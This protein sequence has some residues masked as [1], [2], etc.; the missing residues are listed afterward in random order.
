MEHPHSGTVNPGVLSGLNTQGLP[1]VTAVPIVPIDAAQWALNFPSNNPNLRQQ[2]PNPASS[3][4]GLPSPSPTP[5]PIPQPP[6]QELTPDIE[7]GRAQVKA[8]LDHLSL[9]QYWELLCD[10]GCDTLGDLL[11]APVQLLTRVGFKRLH[12]ARLAAMVHQF[13]RQHPGGVAGT[14]GVGAGQLVLTSAMPG[15]ALVSRKRGSGGQDRGLPPRKIARHV[16]AP[17]NAMYDAPHHRQQYSAPPLETPFA[18]PASLPSTE[19]N[20]NVKVGGGEGMVGQ[21][22]S[23][24]EL[25]FARIAGF[26]P[27]G[28]VLRLGLSCK[29]V[30]RLVSRWLEEKSTLNNSEVGSRYQHNAGILASVFRRCPNL[31]DIT[32][33]TPALCDALVFE[34]YNKLRKISRISL[35][36]C[37][38]LSDRFLSTLLV[39]SHSTLKSVEIDRG[40]RVPIAQLSDDSFVA[41]AG[42]LAPIGG[43]MVTSLTLRNFLHGGL[44]E[45]KLRGVTDSGLEAAARACPKLECL[46]ISRC[47]RVGDSG[48]KGVASSCPLLRKLTLELCRTQNGSP[49]LVTADGIRAISMGCAHLSELTVNGLDADRDQ[50]MCKA[51]GDLLQSHPFVSVLRLDISVGEAPAFWHFQTEDES[52]IYNFAFLT[53]NIKSA[54]NLRELSIGC[55]ANEWG[56]QFL[57][58]V[59]MSCN[60]LEVLEL[61]LTTRIPSEKRDILTN[62]ELIAEKCK[63]K[64]L[65]LTIRQKA[66]SNALDLPDG[67]T[68]DM[69]S[70]LISPVVPGS[71]D[72]N[73]I[74]IARSSRHLT[75]LCL[76]VEGVSVS[77]KGLAQML[78]TLD[79][80]QLISLELAVQDLNS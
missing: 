45:T 36:Q 56:A 50:D 14:G 64:S 34:M 46:T 33:D 62:V 55:H 65:S 48:L 66:Q 69:L 70:P 18:N 9:G 39:T 28:E 4:M 40:D 7:N 73:I 76:R 35:K 74:N 10:H 41:W 78:R 79:G 32:L 37:E 23:V 27:L 16:Q 57:N 8:L 22:T 19:Q 12:A 21:Q 49:P 24:S 58:Q 5:T 17:S 3:S 52:S 67:S 54:H 11:I 6:H 77:D 59:G 15:G 44:N 13:V 51:I 20:P 75:K 68:G 61:L 42:H 26:L 43:S 71:Y 1:I 2:L 47:R 63:L 31:K 72:Q 80:K 38:A 53:E 30:C 60:S 29:A 25:I